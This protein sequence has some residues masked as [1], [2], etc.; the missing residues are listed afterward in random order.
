MVPCDNIV[1]D[2]TSRNNLI[3]LVI[4]I[5]ILGN[6]CQQFV[7]GRDFELDADYKIKRMMIQTRNICEES[8]S[9]DIVH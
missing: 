6:V 3:I 5:I 8:A 1:C 9:Y 4:T 2:K 7:F